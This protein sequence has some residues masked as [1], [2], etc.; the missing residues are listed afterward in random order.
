MSFE[1][2]KQI[3][4]NTMV[5]STF[6]L[7]RFVL[8]FFSA[9]HMMMWPSVFTLL[10]SLTLKACANS[11]RR[12]VTLSMLLWGSNVSKIPQPVFPGVFLCFFLFLSPSSVRI[13]TRR[14]VCT[15]SMHSY[16][17]G[18]NTG[19][20]CRWQTNAVIKSRQKKHILC[21]YLQNPR[22]HDVP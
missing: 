22:I 2:Q 20:Q 19:L 8:C 11:R 18:C 16:G 17:V 6:Y 21:W 1:A 13:Q 10:Y 9:C 15:T 7:L 12:H 14:P 5:L 4:E 3:R